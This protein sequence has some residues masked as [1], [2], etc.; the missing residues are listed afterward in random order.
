MQPLLDIDD[1]AVRFGGVTA[2]SGVS[3]SVM[4]GQICGLIG[5]NGAGKTTVFNCISRIYDPTSGSITY[6]GRDLLK[7]RPH[8]I[9]RLGIMRSFQNLALWPGLTVLEN[10]MM[11]AYRRG[12]VGFLRS[13]LWLGARREEN[14]LA[15]RAYQLLEELDLTDIAFRQCEGLPYGTMKRIELARGLAADPRL[16]ILDEPATGLT[17][18]EV[19]EL[20]DLIRG[21]RDRR[22]LSVLLVEHHMGMVMAL[23]E[24]VVVLDFGR[25][26]AEG[27]PDQVRNDPRVVEAYLGAPDQ[28]DA[29]GASSATSATSATGGTGGEAT[30]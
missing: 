14:S 10:V 20:G 13:P 27:K 2:L 26:I 25:K 4:P 6:D 15:T 18:G 22:D 28:F 9:V 16:L 11:G 1:V 24:H 19:T 12:K 8:T 30:A 21:L 7:E 3:F 17:H 23:C 29:H 5:P